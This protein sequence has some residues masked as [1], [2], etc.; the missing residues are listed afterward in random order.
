[1]MN[2]QSETREETGDQKTTRQARV[3]HLA[4]DACART[5]VGTSSRKEIPS[6]QFRSSARQ[7]S[8]ADEDFETVQTSACWQEPLRFMQ[9]CGQV[10]RE[11]V[12][13]LL[14]AH[15]FPPY[16]SMEGLIN[17]KFHQTSVELSLL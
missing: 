4:K 16:A 13:P 7:I 10:R 8:P 9:R 5:V 14:L 3:Y 15:S 6:R 2:H 1:M 12:P 17:S 11:R